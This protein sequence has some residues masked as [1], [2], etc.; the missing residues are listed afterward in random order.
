MRTITSAIALVLGCVP[1]LAH[2]PGDGHDDHDPAP[3]WNDVA[4][5]RTL[6]GWLLTARADSITIDLHDGGTATVA[7][8][9]LDADGQARAR[10]AAERT[11]SMN[12]G[13]PASTAS[14]LMISTSRD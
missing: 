14:A 11:R 8:A 9:D 6:E 1:C 2:P 10:A 5:G 4:H 13:A 3:A 7:I 12:E